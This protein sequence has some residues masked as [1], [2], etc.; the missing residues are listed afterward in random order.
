MLEAFICDSLLAHVSLN[1]RLLACRSEICPMAVFL[2][3]REGERR[4]PFPRYGVRRAARQEKSIPPGAYGFE[5]YGELELEQGI[6]SL[7]PD[8]C[9]F[10]H[11]V[12]PSL[13]LQGQYYSWVS[14]SLKLFKVDKGRTAQ[15][16]QEN[17][18]Y[19]ILMPSLLLRLKK[20]HMLSTEKRFRSM[21]FC[22]F[23][24]SDVC[25]NFET[26]III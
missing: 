4:S 2:G 6:G 9:D 25:S 15:F 16:F 17:I 3:D 22:F 13:N 21:A 26:N 7:R 23:S 24:S 20:C 12:S 1:G 18:E 8:Q 10:S 19:F 11:L 5:T 14:L